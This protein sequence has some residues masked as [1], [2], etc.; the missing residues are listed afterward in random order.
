MFIFPLY[1]LFPTICYHTEDSTQNTEKMPK[2]PRKGNYISIRLPD[3]LYEKVR[4]MA[5]SRGQ[6]YTEFIRECVIYFLEAREQL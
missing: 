3:V 2:K 4:T 5:D 6:N 1:L